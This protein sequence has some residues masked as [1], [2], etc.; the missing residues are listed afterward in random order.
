MMNNWLRLVGLDKESLIKVG[1]NSSFPHLRYLDDNTLNLFEFDLFHFRLE[2]LK[3]IKMEIRENQI[4][5][6]KVPIGMGCTTLFRYLVRQFKK[7]SVTLH[8][9][10]NDLSLE[11]DSKM[12]SS[13]AKGKFSEIDLETQIKI[14][15]LETIISEPW[16]EISDRWPYWKLLNFEERQRGAFAAYRVE[17]NRLIKS[18]LWK[19]IEYLIPIF[20]QPL[21]DI[22]SYLMKMPTPVSVY[23]MVDLSGNIPDNY[24]S[25]FM[26]A[27]KGLREK[28]RVPAGAFHE[29]YFT[30]STLSYIM[31]VSLGVSQFPS[32]D[33]DW[34][35]YG[36]GEIFEIL[37]KQFS[38]QV[39]PNTLQSKLASEIIDEEIVELAIGRARLKNSYAGLKQITDEI[40]GIIKE[41]L[42]DSHKLPYSIK[43]SS[44]QKQ[45]LDD[46][47]E[48]TKVLS[49]R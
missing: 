16:A 42:K 13:L 32:K 14:G 44:K 30:P 8:I 36:S 33:I 10:V 46:C 3:E 22:L 7:D 45:E 27:V 49:D 1:I 47:R 34:P 4:V 9:I 35:D 11:D 41:S 2:K 17:I 28:L 15:I 40:E 5:R 23:L 38:Y 19:E 39:F 31:D 24:I 29:C 25:L 43:L 37:R 48:Q 18:Q 20:A 21:S 12:K 26:G 6:V